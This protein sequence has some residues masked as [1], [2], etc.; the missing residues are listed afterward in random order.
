MCCAKLHNGNSLCPGS[1]K[2]LSYCWGAP[3][4]ALRLGTALDRGLTEKGVLQLLM[5]VRFLRDAL[6]GGRPGTADGGSGGT[7]APPATSDSRA[8]AERKRAYVELETSL[9]VG[10]SGFTQTRASGLS[11]MINL[12]WL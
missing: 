12:S 1:L 7:P 9:Q 3:R 11:Q 8:L 10:R 5:D 4:D 6:A 2:A